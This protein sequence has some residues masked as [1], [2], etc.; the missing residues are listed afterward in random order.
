[1]FLEMVE[2]RRDLNDAE[3]GIGD[4]KEVLRHVQGKLV[5]TAVSLE[6]SHASNEA[7]LL[8]L[9]KEIS[10]ARRASRSEEDARNLE[11][12][13]VDIAKV[14]NGIVESFGDTA[15]LMNKVMPVYADRIFRHSQDQTD[16][17]ANPK[18]YR[19]VESTSTARGLNRTGDIRN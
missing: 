4:L 8:L 5:L 19:I 7:L 10:L 12:S 6:R 9:K 16:L 2:V 3:G 1:M 14:I 17:V 11:E 15:D 13:L 18:R